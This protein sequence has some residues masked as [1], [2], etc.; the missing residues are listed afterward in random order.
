MSTPAANA[1]SLPVM[2]M[3]PMEGSASKASSARLT[4]LMSWVLSAFSECGRF[5]VMRPT[6][7]SV[8][9]MIVSKAPFAFLC[10]SVSLR[11][12][13]FKNMWF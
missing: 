4:S 2:T 7:P 12:K 10:S 3:Q 8:E 11:A 1:F 13:T 5:S 9:T 6:L